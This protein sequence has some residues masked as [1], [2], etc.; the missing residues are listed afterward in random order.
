[1]P[2]AYVLYYWPTIQGRGELVRLALE[3][4]GAPYED[5][6]R[7]PR[8]MNAMMRLLAGKGPGLAPFAPPI[9]KAGK[10]VIAQTANILAWLATRH[11]LVAPGETN[12]VHAHQ[13]CLT[14]MDFLAE[15]HDVHHPVGTGLYY[16][17]QKK[18]A[19][20]CAAGFLAERIPKFIGYF[21]RV[22]A[23]SGGK[24]AVAGRFS[25]VDLALF[26]VVDGLGYAFPRAWS[27]SRRKAPRLVA[28]HRAVAAHPR[29]AAYLAS[30]RRVPF[31]ED[32]I[33]RHYP[34]LDS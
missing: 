10:L 30:P 3:R 32:G 13:L 2:T 6:A 34:E 9:L 24:H 16:E 22:L 18:E 11:P 5:A 21:E 31:N 26:Q 17:D 29:I 4:V 33:F 20:R 14:V 23:R 28:L 15:V 12:R 27:R 19:R 1:M 25:Y 7:T 8:G